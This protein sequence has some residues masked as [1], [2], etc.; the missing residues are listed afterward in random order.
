M[1]ELPAHRQLTW[2]E[3]HA[4]VWSMPMTRAGRSLG[5]TDTGLRKMC[6]RLKVPIPKQGYW[7]VSPDR[8]EK[9]A[10][11]TKHGLPPS[12]DRFRPLRNPRS[13]FLDAA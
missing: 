11:S 1:P 8:R 13:A 4:L 7:Q 2:E 5:I 6:A 3:L 10:T 9:F 12:Q